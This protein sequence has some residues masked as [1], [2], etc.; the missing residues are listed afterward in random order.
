MVIEMNNGT[1]AVSIDSQEE[2]EEETVRIG[3]KSARKT[4][5]TMNIHQK[6]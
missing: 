4:L 5:A 3:T 1:V 2:E 6:D